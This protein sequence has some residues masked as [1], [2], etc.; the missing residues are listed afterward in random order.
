MFWIIHVKKKKSVLPFDVQSNILVNID[1]GNDN[2][3]LPTPMLNDRQQDGPSKEWNVA[4]WT[5]F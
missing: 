3:P 5:N 4:I 2:N 1:P